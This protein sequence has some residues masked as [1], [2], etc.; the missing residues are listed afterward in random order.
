MGVAVPEGYKQTKVGVIP[1]DWD[2]LKLDDI[3]KFYKGKGISKE[4]LSE[5]G[6]PCI[7]YGELY[8]TYNEKINNVISKTDLDAKEL[9]LSQANDIIIPASGETAID[10]ATASCVLSH[11]IALGSDLNVIR[12]EHNG[13]FLSYYLNFIAKHRIASLAQGI[14]VIHLYPTQLKTLLVAL[15]PLIVQEKIVDILTVWDEAITRQKALIKAKEQFKKGLMQKLFSG[16]VRFDGFDGKWDI[17][18][19]GDIFYELKEKIGEQDIET[20]SISAGIGFVSQQA[21]FGKNISG[22][23]NVNYIVVKENQFSYNKGNSKTYQYGCIYPNKTNKPIAVPNVFIS[24]DLKDKAM[25]TD[26]YAKLFEGHYLDRELRKIISSSARMDGLLNINKK[27]FFEIPIICP[28]IK[29]Q[30]KIAG[31]LIQ[32]DKEIDLLKNELEALKE[33]KRGLMQKLLT[34]EVRVNNIKQKKSQGGILK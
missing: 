12:T 19:L 28:S 14:S 3:G 34:G 30:Q 10:I 18:R 23:Q 26:F 4:N 17:V 7:R 11:N 33:Q 25:S 16:E 6:T 15:P 31:V 27:Y 9:F 20:Y 22:A 1:E 13:I 32:A 5:N 21:K 8:T 29:E 24:F 2:V